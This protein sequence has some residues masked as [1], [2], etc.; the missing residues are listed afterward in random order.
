M[1]LE[2]IELVVNS[3][4][5]GDYH[6]GPMVR[7]RYL[8]RKD[9]AQPNVRQVLLVDT[10]MLASL[11]ANGIVLGPGMMG[12]NLVLDG[13]SV[14]EWAIGTIVQVGDARLE[15]TEVRTP[16]RQLNGM[17]PD[18]LAAVSARDGGRPNA[19]VFARVLD[20]GR[21]TPGDPVRIVST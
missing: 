8:A 15:V 12:E 13:V 5:D 10:T 14:M 18:L 7:H 11:A 21:V 16:C 19:G 6:S 2:A 3:G 20:G 17:H 4:V 9:P 1:P